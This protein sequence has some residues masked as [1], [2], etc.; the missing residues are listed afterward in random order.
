M[1]RFT[2]A[3]VKKLNPQN[4]TFTKTEG[5][6]LYLRINPGGSKVW[7]HHY[8]IGTL[9]KWYRIGEYPAVSLKEAREQNEDLLKISQRGEDPAERFTFAPTVKEFAEDWIEKAVDRRGN[10][11]SKAHR[12]NAEYMFKKDVYPRIG[13]VKVREVHKRDIRVL[14]QKVEQRAPNQALQLYRRLNRLFNHAAEQ[15]IIEVSPM[16]NLPPIGRQNSRARYLTPEEIKTF[17][18]GLPLADAAPQTATILE[19]ILRTGQR[20]SEVCGARQSEISGDW[21]ILPPERTKNKLEHR[22][23][24]AEAVKELFGSPN[25]HGLFF[26]SLRDESKPVHHGV[27]AKAIR[28]S[29]DG[30]EKTQRDKTPTLSLGRFTPHDL[31]RTCATYLGELSFTDE[32][33]GAVLN[34]KKRSVTG[35]YNQFA[36][37]PQKKRAMLAWDRR[38]T[39]ILTGEQQTDS[40]VVSIG[41]RN[42]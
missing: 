38:L 21:W 42:G 36:Y 7:F 13:G 17:L 25:E 27:L 41:G 9:R 4:S 26:P 18:T 32:V 22:V 5:G 31:R 23:Y 16:V 35:R 40:K 12:S 14:I 20:S 8:K 29:L 30:S 37:D 11:W 15:D 1:E 28:R 24:L 33:I 10:P 39:E 34:H 6:G 3:V 2:D 19:I